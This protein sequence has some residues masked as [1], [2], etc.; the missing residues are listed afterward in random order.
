MSLEVFNNMLPAAFRGAEF[1]I[2]PDATTTG[3]RKTVTHEFL[4]SS[5]RNVE[6]LGPLLKTFQIRATIT[7]FKEVRGGVLSTRLGYFEARD[8]LIKA[9]EQPGVGVLIHPFLGRVNVV[10]KPYSFTESTGDIGRAVFTLVF[11]AADE[12]VLPTI[13]AGSP[14]AVARV[15]TTTDNASEELTGAQVSPLAN[16][17]SQFSQTKALLD[18]VGTAFTDIVELFSQGNQAVAQLSADIQNFQDNIVSLINNPLALANG[19]RGIFDQ[20]RVVLAVPEERLD[21]IKKLF[22]FNS[23][24]ENLSIDT[25]V[26]NAI[27]ENTALAIQ[28]EKT[29]TLHIRVNA[30]SI[31]Y[32]ALAT[33][34]FTS[35]QD[36]DNSAATVEAEYQSIIADPFLP[37]EIANNL[38]DLRKE[39][40]LVLQARRLSVNRVIEVD[41]NSTPVQ[42]LAYQ[43]YGQTTRAEDLVDL[44]DDPDVSTYEGLIKVLTA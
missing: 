12:A 27:S 42:V 34:E 17:P 22:G 31:A 39:T 20:I 18:E 3:G 21:V 28:N 4:N 2:D 41:I 14:G 1:L 43:L 7:D 32:T 29:I 19:I 11:E 36:L 40:N 5:R 10:A 33:I 6:D 9:L 44:N 25:D 35:I 13:R 8:R 15:S 24:S 23:E 26:G 38:S 16:A 37:S 30:L